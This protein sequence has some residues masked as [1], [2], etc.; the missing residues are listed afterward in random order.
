MTI[1]R[2]LN[3]EGITVIERTVT[4]GIGRDKYYGSWRE[5]RQSSKNYNSNRPGSKPYAG[6]LGQR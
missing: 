4:T 5:I 2:I 1:K 3:K 6:N